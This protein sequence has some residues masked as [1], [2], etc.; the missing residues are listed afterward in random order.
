M[1]YIIY[2]FT[3]QIKVWLTLFFIRKQRSYIHTWRM[4]KKWTQLMWKLIWQTSMSCNSHN[5]IA[6]ILEYS[7]SSNHYNSATVTAI[8]TVQFH[9]F[10]AAALLLKYFWIMQRSSHINLSVY[11]TAPT[12][13]HNTWEILFS[14][15]VTSVMYEYSSSYLCYG[16]QIPQFVDVLWTFGDLRYSVKWQH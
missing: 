5:C 9:I 13:Q 12:K 15:S 8:H 14:N 2:V 10:G 11:N 6:P 1:R 16:C 4:W 7:K 3:Q